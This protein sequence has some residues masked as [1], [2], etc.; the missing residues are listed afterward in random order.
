MVVLFQRNT[1]GG[2]VSSGGGPGPSGA[3]AGRGDDAEIRRIVDRRLVSAEFQPVVALA[4]RTPWAFE[5]LARGPV[6]S[7]LGSPGAMFA[8]ATRV[9]LAG[10]LDRVAHA[11][12]FGAVIDNA[13]G[14][15]LPVS[16]NAAPLGL[17]TPNPE[18]LV[19]VAESARNQFPVIVELAES[20]V[21]ADP[22]TALR[23]VD[24]ARADGLRIA[25]DNVGLAP[26]SFVLLPLLRPDL[27]KLDR[28]LVTDMHAA[29]RLI[30]GLGDYFRHSGVHVVVQGVEVEEHLALAVAMGARYGQGY[31]FGRPLPL[32]KGNGEPTWESSPDTGADLVDLP[33]AA[34]DAPLADI[35]VV[36]QVAARMT[37]RAEAHPDPACIIMVSPAGGL[38]A[39]TW[40][41][42]RPLVKRSAL[43]AVLTADEPTKPIPDA[44]THTLAATDPLA[45]QFALAILTTDG[46]TLLTAQPATDGAEGQYRYTQTRD[47]ET[48]VGVCRSLLRQCSAE[49]PAG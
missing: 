38:A 14:Y 46:A 25:V 13:P 40:L 35:G 8:A 2:P 5:A 24:R 16:V 3:G 9:G 23:A 15:H 39:D 49:L 21:V 37:Q 27:V 10:E 26:A 44:V 36:R 48:V 20:A 6:S 12:A 7:S 18:D 31:L 30:D 45:N 41:L 42:P 17:L 32:P 33:S 19:E 29:E 1:A 4:G 22:L 43:T 11:A 28:S 47:R 34:A